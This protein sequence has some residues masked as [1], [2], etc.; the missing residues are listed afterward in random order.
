MTL[1]SLRTAG[2][3][4]AGVGA[5]HFVA[6]G[7]YEPITAPVFPDD[8]RSWIYRNGATELALGLALRN[9]SRTLRAA[10]LAGLLGYTLWLGTN[11]AKNR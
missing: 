1:L 11:A 7:L 6:P 4:L 3:L 10:G 9:N 5:S 2:T 8:T